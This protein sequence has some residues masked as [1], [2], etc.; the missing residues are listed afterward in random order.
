M[1]SSK[2]LSMPP[3]FSPTNTQEETAQREDEVTLYLGKYYEA[4]I[5]ASVDVQVVARLSRMSKETRPK[6]LLALALAVR[7]PRHGHICVD[8]LRVAESLKPDM[9]DEEPAPSFDWPEPTKWVQDVHS[10]PLVG[11]A[12]PEQ[13]CPFVLMGSVLYTNRYH[14]Y[15]SQL[16][17]SLLQR[18]R[19]PICVPVD[20]EAFRLG[21]GELFI[22]KNSDTQSQGVNRQMLSAAVACLRPLTVVSGGPGMGKTW[23]VRNILALLYSQ[24]EILRQLNPDVLPLRVALAAPSGKA[25]ARMHESILKN[26]GAFSES[27]AQCFPNVELIEKT[28]SFL[29]NDLHTST[30]HRLLG[31]QSRTPT[32]FRHHAGN[33]LPFDVVIVDETSM[34]DLAMM[35]RIVQ[36]T[37][38]AA[39]LIFLGDKYQLASVEAGTVLED[40]CGP[41]HAENLQMDGSFMDTLS[42][43]CELGSDEQIHPTG[44]SPVANC[45]VH[46]NQNHRFKADSGIGAFA[47]RSLELSRQDLPCPEKVLEVFD[48]DFKDVALLPRDR[49]SGQL[50]REAEA[51]ICTGFEPYLSLLCE[52]QVEHGQSIDIHLE[53]IKRF[54][55]FRLLAAH[56]RGQLGVAGLNQRVEKLLGSHFGKLGFKPRGQFY[57]GRPVIVRQ[58]DYSLGLFNGDVGLVV[59][60]RLPDGS[61]GLQVVFPGVDG[62]ARY[63]AP[64]RLPQHDTVF[65]MTIHSSQG[66]EFEHVMV[67]LPAESSTVLSRELIYTAVTRAAK[68]MTMVGSRA[69]LETALMTRLERA[70]GLRELLWQ[71]TNG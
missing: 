13:I 62:G 32:R 61:P 4:G 58:N 52:T 30:I 12:D 26:L 17:T 3:I 68:R 49:T 1:N 19:H 57:A 23:T 46:F 34:V 38:L 24:R 21:L 56:R 2:S 42:Q 11:G 18:A 69:V 36:A 64:T 43:F 9:D 25:A 29:R 51:I 53:L 65:A 37:P 22:S 33:P 16:A 20:E 55:K 48:G 41:T 15:Q 45:I 44:E 14:R 7:A 5:L 50:G 59:P 28:L 31:F 67:V 40:I 71:K 35:S 47:S 70:S 63:V 60:R 10:S 66:S 8:L 27:L 6:V 39:K 54:D